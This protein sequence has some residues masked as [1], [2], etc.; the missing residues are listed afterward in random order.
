M[1]MALSYVVFRA[2]Y[3][4][5]HVGGAGLSVCGLAVLLLSDRGQDG[6]SGTRPLLGD[7]LVIAGAALYAVGN[8]MQESLL[9][10]RSACALHCVCTASVHL[11]YRLHTHILGRASVLL[12][13]LWT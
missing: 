2:R 4:L 12:D 6:S 11:Y 8:V 3:R 9:G 1:V 13:Y 7:L 10:E 5:G